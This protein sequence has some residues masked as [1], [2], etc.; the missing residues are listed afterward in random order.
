MSRYASVWGEFKI[1]ISPLGRWFRVPDNIASICLKCCVLHQRSKTWL[2]PGLWILQGGF[3]PGQGS[4]VLHCH[5]LGCVQRPVSPVLRRLAKRRTVAQR[6]VAHS[7]DDVSPEM[8]AD[9]FGESGP[10][11]ATQLKMYVSQASRFVLSTPDCNA[12][13]T[14]LIW[15]V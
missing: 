4:G 12:P 11:S 7:T 9:D 10:S 15:Y 3:L 13:I 5:R 1:W 14:N 8:L 2:Q 6:R